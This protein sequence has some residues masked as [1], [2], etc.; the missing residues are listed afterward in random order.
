MEIS[1]K[2]ILASLWLFLFSLYWGICQTQNPNEKPLSVLQR[3]AEAGNIAAQAKL[4]TMYLLGDGVEKNGTL[5]LNWSYQAAIAGNPRAARNVG[6][7]YLDGLGAIKS[8]RAA[9]EW[10][11]IAAN[12]DDP[13]AQGVL[14][15]LYRRGDGVGKDL[16]LSYAWALIRRN[17]GDKRSLPIIVQLEK[18]LVEEQRN[19]AIALVA[20]WGK[21]KVHLIPAHSK[22]YCDNV[23]EGAYVQ[24]KPKTL[25]QVSGGCNS[26]HWISDNIDDGKYIKLEDGSLWEVNGVDT[27]DSSLWLEMDDII[28]CN[29]KLINTDDK[30][31]V[32]AKR[33]NK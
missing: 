17:A 21:N 24:D 5:G 10:F 31:S 32:E 18:E 15:I 28:V 16:T 27:V 8:S 20:A 25:S 22:W 23:P 11:W 9:F 3:E 1:V 19:E 7:A 12:R 4:G 26:G 6:F 2:Q 13:G 33:V 14:S 30:E 29:G